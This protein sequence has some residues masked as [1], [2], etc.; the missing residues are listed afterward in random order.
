MCG[1]KVEGISHSRSSRRRRR[2]RQRCSMKPSVLVVSAAVIE[3]WKCN[4]PT[5]RTTYANIETSEVRKTAKI[6]WQECSLR[7]YLTD[8]NLKPYKFNG[9]TLNCQLTCI[10]PVVCFL[11]FNIAFTLQEMLYIY[12][13]WGMDMEEG[14]REKLRNRSKV[15]RSTTAYKRREKKKPIQ[16]VT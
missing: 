6:W 16:P 7:H 1:L 3:S 10:D 14:K 2:Y 13:S 5:R 9:K 15:A 11:L 12:I 8:E 4:A